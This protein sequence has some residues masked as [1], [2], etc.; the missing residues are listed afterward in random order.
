MV[1]S[2]L[3]PY[4]MEAIDKARS[5]SQVAIPAFVTPPKNK[6]LSKLNMSCCSSMPSL[7]TSKNVHT[8]N[9]TEVRQRPIRRKTTRKDLCKSGTYCEESNDGRVIFQTPLQRKD[10]VIKDLKAAIINRRVSTF[11]YFTS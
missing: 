6:V 5:P 4:S 11:I 3:L 1:F 9:K 7:N 8:S 10:T 2:K